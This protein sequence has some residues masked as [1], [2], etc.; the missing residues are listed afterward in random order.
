MPRLGL[1]ARLRLLRARMR[2]DPADPARRWL[3]R[4]WPWLLLLYLAGAG[5]ITLDAWLATCGFVGCPTRTQIRAFRPAEGG[6]IL[7]RNGRFLG[8]VSAV[9]R[10]NVALANVPLHVRQAFVATEDRRFYEHNGLDWRGFARAAVRNVASGGVREGFSTITMQVA[11]TAF[12][13]DRYHGR[14]LRRKLIELRLTRLIERELTKD[15]ILEHYLNVIFLGNGMNGVEAASRDLFGKGVPE[16]SVA[17]AAMLAA[18]PKAPSVYSPR[19][20]PE[21]ARR[22]RDLVLALMT[23]EG[24]LTP[25][26]AQRAQAERVRVANTEWRPY[27]PNEVLALEAVRQFVDS[28]LP[29]V[30]KDG[31][32]AV[33]TTLDTQA[34]RAADRAIQRHAAAIGRTIQ[35]ALVALDPRTGD[36]RALVPGRQLERRGF[37]RAIAAKRQPGSAFKPF[38]YAAA[39][40]SGLSPA[41]MVDDEPVEVRTGNQVWAPGNY[42]DVY[43]GRVTLRKA[44]QHS[45]NAATVRVSRAVG[46]QNVIAAAHRNGIRSRLP[47]YPAIA[48]GAA[49]VTPMELV[50]AYAPFANGGMRVQPRLVTR[51]E[52]ADGTVLWAS[53]IRREPAMD[54]R[55]AYMM[56]SMLRAVVDH[57]TGHGVRD[58]GIRGAVG[59]KTGTTNNAADVWFVG[60][61]P[62]LVAGVWFGYDQPRQMAPG[63]SGGR[64]AVPAWSEFYRNGWREPENSD[65]AVP[66]GMVARIIDPATGELATEYCP[67]R[68]REWFRIGREPTEPCT[69]HAAPPDA[70]DPWPES[71]I[72]DVRREVDRAKRGIGGILRRIFRF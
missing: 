34:Q 45:A 21:R 8:R 40:Q 32:V 18:L 65:F 66:Q 52:A 25:D 35:G 56:T 28:I 13:S 57:G 59:G 37:N 9:R 11:R 71:G 51:V 29:D 10:V 22:R 23:K 15:Q 30:Q 50:T 36:V 49:E 1:A 24:Y 33:F 4:H 27:D 70:I 7:D 43:F 39:L 53:E 62:T 14:S 54:P 20:N 42:D 17:D 5:T 63:A 72:P 67:A 38:V 55:D 69:Q 47:N 2:P 44:L 48:L 64:F 26:R 41:T 3:R 46:E 68:A 60:F 31:D 58:W 12:L 61:T 6:R 19:K 16:L